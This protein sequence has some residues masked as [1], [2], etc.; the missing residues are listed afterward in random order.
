MKVALSWSYGSHG[1]SIQLMAESSLPTPIWKSTCSSS[2]S[3]VRRAAF[4]LLS[5]CA[6]TYSAGRWYALTI[7]EKSSP[8]SPRRLIA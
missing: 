1:E 7:A 2:A 3:R 4:P 6:F 5:P 8:P